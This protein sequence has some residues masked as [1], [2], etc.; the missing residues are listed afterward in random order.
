M[1]TDATLRNRADAAAIGA[2]TVVTN[3]VSQGI[4][5][6]TGERQI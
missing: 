6:L 5:R 3:D 4:L 2:S 1:N